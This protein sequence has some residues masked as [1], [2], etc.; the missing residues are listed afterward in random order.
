MS[1]LFAEQR[2]LREAMSLLLDWASAGALVEPP[3]REYALDDV[4]GAHRDLESGDTVGK[5]VLIP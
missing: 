1:Y 3:I 2:L 4:A 5:L